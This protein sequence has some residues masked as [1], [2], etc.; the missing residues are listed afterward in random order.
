MFA[1]IMICWYCE[2]PE[3]HHVSSLFGA[4]KCCDW[5]SLDSHLKWSITPFLRSPKM[6]HFQRNSTLSFQKFPKLPLSARSH[7]DHMLQVVLRCGTFWWRAQGNAPR[8]TYGNVKRWC[9]NSK[10]GTIQV[11]GLGPWPFAIH[12]VSAGLCITWDDLGSCSEHIN[13]FTN[14]NLGVSIIHLY[15]DLLQ[16]PG[17]QKSSWH[18]SWS[19]GER[20]NL[21][22]PRLYHTP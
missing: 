18:S 5:S 17:K 3:F 8:K 6:W 14:L 2:N 16:S 21:K 13:P 9:S 15:F 12:A 10:N 7:S 1:E 19:D 20:N 22:Q 4:T 11:V